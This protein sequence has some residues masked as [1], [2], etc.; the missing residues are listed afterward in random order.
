MPFPAFPR[1][2]E[3]SF[4]PKAAAAGFVALLGCGSIASSASSSAGDNDDATDPLDEFRVSAG[5]HDRVAAWERVWVE[6]RRAAGRD[7]FTALCLSAGGANGAFGAGVIAGWTKSGARPTFDVV[8]GVSTGALIAPFVFAGPAWDQR[9]SEAY[10]DRRL[11]A[12]GAGRVGAMIRWGLAALFPSRPIGGSPLTR[13]VADHADAALLQAIAAEH[14][15]GRRLLTATT[16]LDTQECVIWDLGAIAAASLRPDDQGRAL[17]LFHSVL[18]ASASVPGLFPP[19]PIAR[20]LHV[21]GAVSTPFFLPPMSWRTAPGR[22]AE[23]YLVINGSLD[24]TYRA[25]RRGALPV[26]MRALDTMGRANARARVAATEI[27]AERQGAVM[28]YAAIPDDHPADPFDFRPENLCAQFAFGY[29]QAAR[30]L[31]FRAT[32]LGLVRAS[33][34]T[35]EAA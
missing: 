34:M 3:Q 17:R 22:P 31:A 23:L 35:A 1:N 27:L 5:D 20:E 10:R 4:A 32:A 33:E 29:A 2:N 25:T 16:N 11:R 15:R 14:R 9:L 12:L 19:T 18:V 26:L 13:L 7:A 21:D 8:T 28:T 6:Q 24:P 30:G